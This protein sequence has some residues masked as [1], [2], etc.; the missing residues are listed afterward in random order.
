[1]QITLR[2]GKCDF[3]W[4]LPDNWGIMETATG[5]RDRTKVRTY[6]VK[7]CL[8]ANW[9]KKEYCWGNGDRPCTGSS[10]QVLAA[11][12]HWAETITHTAL[13]LYSLRTHTKP[14][15]ACVHVSD[16]LYERRMFWCSPSV[17]AR[18]TD[19]SFACSSTPCG[20]G[21]EGMGE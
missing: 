13:L 3:T 16:S 9:Q 8:K 18:W 5:E 4:V 21:R 14:H 2:R 10:C 20:R 1:M 17:L 15:S 11:H 7:C 12:Q 6:V 19:T